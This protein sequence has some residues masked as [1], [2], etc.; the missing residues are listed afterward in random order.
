LAKVTL[1]RAL[2]AR[3]SR[4]ATLDAGAPVLAASLGVDVLVGAEAVAVLDR[5]LDLRGRSRVASPDVEVALGE[6][7]VGTL[8]L[9]L[10]GALAPV[11]HATEG[12]AALDVNADTGVVLGLASVGAGRG[13][14]GAA[15][16]V[17]VASVGVSVELEGS[18]AGVVGLEVTA[19]DERKI[20][21][22]SGVAGAIVVPPRRGLRADVAGSRGTRGGSA[23]G[24]SA[25]RSG[26][27]AR[28]D[29]GGCGG[30]RTA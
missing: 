20:D 10:G 15:V 7:G 30:S 14:L 21:L 9:L 28:V 8:K 1:P 26:R 4:K 6:A 25:G 24:N 23:G 16:G 2:P 12:L 29:R 27:G 3:S 19:G 5:A 17:A 18:A 11:V 13:S 22:A